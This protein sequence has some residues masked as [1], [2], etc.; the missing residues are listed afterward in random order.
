MRFDCRIFIFAAAALAAAPALAQT[1]P[2]T[3]PTAPAAA[4]PASPTA[5][6]QTPP[7]PVVARV[8]NDAIHLSDISAAADSLPAQ[9]HNMSAQAL[10][11]L[12]LDQAIDRIALVAYARSKNIDKDPAVERQMQIA[13]NQV[14]ADEMMRREVSPQLTEAAIR[15]RYDATVADKPGEEEVHARHILV[16]TEAEANKIIAELKKGADFATEAKQHS[17][18]PGGKDGG[19]L[20]FFKKG[21]MLP[22]F[23]DAAFAMKPG[24]VS[25][26]PVKTQYGWHVIKVEERRTAPP[27]TYAEVHDQLRQ[28]LI[29]DDVQKVLAD[30]RSGMKVEKFNP[31]GSAIRATDTAQPPP[32][33]PAQQKP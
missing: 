8:G 3:P 17:T 25:D 23:A 9:Y 10:Y 2:A 5:N 22:E 14:L 33:P 13:A 28:Q 26:K 21:D 24:Q 20:G 18:D 11:P 30:A 12:L 7:D 32:A 1:A 4:P 31:D 15:A 19:D 16:A 29:Q 27:P 6:A